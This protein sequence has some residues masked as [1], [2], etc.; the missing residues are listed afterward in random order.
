MLKNGHP[1]LTATAAR[2]VILYGRFFFACLT[3]GHPESSQADESDSAVTT[4]AH[5]SS[6]GG[7]SPGL[8]RRLRHVPVKHY[9]RSGERPSHPPI[10]VRPPIDCNARPG[11][12]DDKFEARVAS[13]S[14]EDGAGP[15]VRSNDH[16][17][18]CQDLFVIPQ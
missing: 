12:P 13:R 7:F 10:G 18:R 17:P 1:N 16:S 4:A 5:K 3:T 2:H 8:F 14:L 11:R 6:G 9:R 15:Q